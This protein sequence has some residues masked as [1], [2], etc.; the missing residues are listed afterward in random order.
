MHARQGEGWTGA[1]CELHDRAMVSAAHL[2]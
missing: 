2:P 1:D